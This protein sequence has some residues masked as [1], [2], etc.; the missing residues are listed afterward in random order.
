MYKVNEKKHVNNACQ[1][2]QSMLQ[3]IKSQLNY[4]VLNFQL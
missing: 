2:F 3:M 4:Y 1:K